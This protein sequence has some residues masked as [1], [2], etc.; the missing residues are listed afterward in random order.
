MTTEVN[1]LTTAV[2]LI[3]RASDPSIGT[4]SESVSGLL[5][6]TIRGTTP[7]ASTPVSPINSGAVNTVISA[8]SRSGSRRRIAATSAESTERTPR[9]EYLPP[10]GHTAVR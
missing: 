1:Q 4:S 3:T 9:S 7:T 2:Q 6:T 5:R 10:T 8:A